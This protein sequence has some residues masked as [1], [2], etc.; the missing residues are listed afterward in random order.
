M[1]KHM[2]GSMVGGKGSGTAKGILYIVEMPSILT[3]VV[4]T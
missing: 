2:G 1:W 4:F 3:K